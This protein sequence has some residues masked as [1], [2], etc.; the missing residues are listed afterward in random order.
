MRSPAKTPTKHIQSSTLHRNGTLHSPTHSHIL[1]CPKLLLKYIRLYRIATH[2]NIIDESRAA[3]SRHLH[4]FPNTKLSP[5][6]RPKTFT[7]SGLR[8]S[9]PTEAQS[10]G[11]RPK[12]GKGA[13]V[14]RTVHSKTQVIAYRAVVCGMERAY[15]QR[16][17]AEE[18]GNMVHFE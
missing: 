11:K 16:G 2:H 6:E 18:L 8:K 17:A 14:A 7:N 1:K 4:L 5:L 3:L 15:K 10:K 12:G 13:A 9:F